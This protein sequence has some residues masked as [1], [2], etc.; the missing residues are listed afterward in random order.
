MTKPRGA[1]VLQFAIGAALL[2]LLMLP[3]LRQALESSMS[4]HMLVQ[5]PALVLAGALVGV[6]LPASLAERLSAWNE[7][8]MAGLTACALSFAVLMIPR[9]L[10]LVLID[11]RVEAAKVVALLF[12]GAVL[13]PSW[14]AAGLVIQGFF[15]GGVLPMTI[16]V[17]TLYRDSPIRL[18]NAYRI[19][20]QQRLGLG[21]LWIA[22][23][24]AVGWFSHA[25]RHLRNSAA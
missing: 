9:V 22:G 16:V 2:V 8:G 10:D 6:A 7:L 23:V 4:L 17:A 5:Y 11:T 13:R 1:I 14:R 25:A 24:V 19:D 20:D 12:A 3:P 21:L 15:L 18:C